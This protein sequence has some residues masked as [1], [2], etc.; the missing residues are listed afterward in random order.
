MQFQV[1]RSRV[2]LMRY[3]RMGS[4]SALKFCSSK[5]YKARAHH[6]LSFL[7]NTSRH[8]CRDA[9]EILD[10]KPVIYLFPPPHLTFTNPY[11]VTV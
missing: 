1:L 10:Q 4:R 8:T 11:A 3:Y 6:G 5:G 2:R 9:E 7:V